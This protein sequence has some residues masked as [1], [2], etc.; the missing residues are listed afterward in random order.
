MVCEGVAVSGR[1]GFVVLGNELRLHFLKNE[2]LVWVG[3]GMKPWLLEKGL[4]FY[5]I[6]IPWLWSEKGHMGAW[7]M[8]KKLI[9]EIMEALWLG[10]NGPKGGCWVGFNELE[11][12]CVLAREEVSGREKYC[13]LELKDGGLI[14]Y[15]KGMCRALV[16]RID[17]E[18]IL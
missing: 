1:C 15:R 17:M 13:G 14:T 11:L 18:N 9:R 5:R 4:C 6:E 2:N 10:L 8:G 12:F 7:Y 3:R 16:K